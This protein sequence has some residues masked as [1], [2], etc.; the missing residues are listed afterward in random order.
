M[1]VFNYC[2]LSAKLHMFLAHTC[3]VKPLMFI[4]RCDMLK[5]D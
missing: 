3:I 5:R 2:V 1:D 4:R